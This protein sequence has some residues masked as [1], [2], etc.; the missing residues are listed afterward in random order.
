MLG[1]VVF[2]NQQHKHTLKTQSSVRI[3][4]NSKLKSQNYY[5]NII[6]ILNQHIFC[7]INKKKSNEAEYCLILTFMGLFRT[8]IYKIISYMMCYIV[9]IIMIIIIK[10]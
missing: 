7:K 4:T 6:E 8:K 1:Y 9:I 5:N 10:G 3:S 2:L